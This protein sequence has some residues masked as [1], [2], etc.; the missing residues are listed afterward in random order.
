MAKSFLIGWNEIGR[1]ICYGS[2]R[3]GN[4]A[5][6]IPFETMERLVAEGMPVFYIPELDS[7]P[8]ATKADLMRWLKTRTVQDKPTVWE[9]YHGANAENKGES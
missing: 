8:R 1:F 9:G 4:L 3:G 6:N 7:T 5:A 2:E